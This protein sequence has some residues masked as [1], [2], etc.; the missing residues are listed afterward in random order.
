MPLKSFVYSAIASPIFLVFN[1]NGPNFYDIEG[2]KLLSPPN[3]KVL[4]STNLLV[5]Y[6]FFIKDLI[7]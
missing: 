3:T 2:G 1:P 6:F 4:I 7:I 5:S